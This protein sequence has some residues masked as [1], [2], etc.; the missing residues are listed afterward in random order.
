MSDLNGLNSRKLAIRFS[1]YDRDQGARE[2]KRGRFL[3]ATRWDRLMNFVKVSMELT[4]TIAKHPYQTLRNRPCT[5][6]FMSMEIKQDHYA[7]EYGMK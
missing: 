3:P 6:V 7:I 1:R 2:L 4:Y 5:H